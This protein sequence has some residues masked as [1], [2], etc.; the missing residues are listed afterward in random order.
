MRNYFFVILISV[1]NA[2]NARA[3]DLAARCLL[4]QAFTVA[5]LKKHGAVVGAEKLSVLEQ[6]VKKILC[7]EE[8]FL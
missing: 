6:K 2:G 5:S 8:K 4:D 3:T 1:C 7:M